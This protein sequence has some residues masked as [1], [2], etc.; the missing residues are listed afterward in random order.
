VASFSLHYLTFATLHGRFGA[1]EGTLTIDE[2]EPS[3]S[4]V[5]AS[6][7]VTTIVTGIH[8]RDAHLRSSQFFHASRYPKVTFRSKAV[9]QE[10]ENS[11]RIAGDLTVRS[12]TKPV[13]LETFYEGPAVNPRGVSCA[14]F[15]AST[16]LSR[17]AF[18]LGR[19]GDSLIVSDQVKVVLQITAVRARPDE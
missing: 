3:R 18:G 5:S 14:L 4:T 17:R 12:I 19:G 1:V 6:I 16:V 13:T 8:L 11:W 7:D 9:E 2:D 10:S 15:S